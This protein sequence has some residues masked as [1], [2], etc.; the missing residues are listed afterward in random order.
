MIYMY[1]SGHWLAFADLWGYLAAHVAGLSHR[2]GVV[3][4]N[5]LMT[6]TG[7]TASWFTDELRRLDPNTLGHFCIYF[8][9]SG[10]MVWHLVYFAVI[11]TDN[12]NHDQSYHHLILWSLILSILCSIT[13]A[14]IIFP[15]N[16]LIPKVTDPWLLRVKN[17]AH[18]DNLMGYICAAI[19][20][21]IRFLGTVASVAA[22]SLIIATRVRTRAYFSS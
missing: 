3:C 2:L 6:G 22:M 7:I 18:T 1:Y 11:S 17:R 12:V 10:C 19:S 13:V 21:R 14:M 5:T 9:T 16:K 15:E 4:Y 20:Y 8:T